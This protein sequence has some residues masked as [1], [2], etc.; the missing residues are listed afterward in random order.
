MNIPFEDGRTANSINISK[1]GIYFKTKEPIF[2]G[3]P[4]RV[5]IEMSNQCS[6]KLPERVVYTGRI[7]RVAT[8]SRGHSL[9]AGVG[10]EFFYSEA[11]D[12]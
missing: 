3:L 10:I 8:K 12:R 5:L 7:S 9:S 1:R 6:G 2:A 11:F 4:V